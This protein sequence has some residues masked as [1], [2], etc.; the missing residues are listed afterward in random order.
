ML[1][2]CNLLTLHEE[3]MKFDYPDWSHCHHCWWVDIVD[4]YLKPREPVTAIEV[5]CFEGRST[6]WF[7]DHFLRAEN[8]K[9]FCIDAWS[10]GEEVSRLNLG[11][12]M[13][14]VKANF[15][16]NINEHPMKNKI[17]VISDISEKALGNLMHF[18]RKIDFIY[19]DGSHTRRDTLVDL[20]Y[21]TSLIKQGGVI[22]V[23]DYLN[24]MGT[25]N[26][27]LRPKNAVNFIV[28]SMGNEFDFFVTPEK[29]GVLIRRQ[30]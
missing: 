26:T 18:Y 21:C 1:K 24:K 10:G 25:N 9:M 3:N 17:S 12:D 14:V 16:N 20:V 5:G 6:L 30:L 7:A 19:L 13:E 28:K 11:Y 15:F 27:K 22:I 4:T 2:V 29:Q 23:D 8:S